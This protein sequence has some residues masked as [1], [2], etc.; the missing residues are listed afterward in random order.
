LKE[1]VY[2]PAK[3]SGE[4][5]WD[6]L[7]DDEFRR[8]ISDRRPTH[9]RPTWTSLI[10]SF[11]TYKVPSHYYFH[12]NGQHNKWRRQTASFTL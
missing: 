7:R 5:G 3:N 11:F 10:P 6:P 9:H 2:S 8:L 1:F 4:G 12:L